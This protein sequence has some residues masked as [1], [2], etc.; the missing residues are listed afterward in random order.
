MGV[1]ASGFRLSPSGIPKKDAGIS[2]DP[3][4]VTGIVP[5]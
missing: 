5:R 2:F 3:D 1:V 4:D